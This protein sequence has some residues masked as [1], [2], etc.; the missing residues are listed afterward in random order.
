MVPRSVKISSLRT[1][2]H[3]SY[4]FALRVD[5]YGPFIFQSLPFLRRV[6][7]GFQV[8]AAGPQVVQ[9]RGPRRKTRPGEIFRDQDKIEITRDKV[10][11][12]GPAAKQYQTVQVH[13]PFQGRGKT[14]DRYRRFSIHSKTS[15][16]EAT[17]R[18]A[19]VSSYSASGGSS[20]ALG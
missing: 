4:S 6:A 1:W 20:A 14:L 13:L 12:P 18:A 2:S 10:V 9:P 7:E 15:L 11:P 3:E 17:V 19:I 5:Q 8:T 16:D